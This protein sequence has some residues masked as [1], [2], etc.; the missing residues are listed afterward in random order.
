MH[1]EIITGMDAEKYYVFDPQSGMSVENL[2]SEYSAS[3]STKYL[4]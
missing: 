1:A 3:N 2:A 4:L